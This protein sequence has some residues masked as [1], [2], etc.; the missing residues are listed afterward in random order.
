MEKLEQ[1]ALRTAPV[2]C[3][4]RL[5]KRYVGDILEAIKKDQIAGFTDHLNAVDETRSIKFT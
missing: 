4:P 5:W 2:N 1:K 3:K